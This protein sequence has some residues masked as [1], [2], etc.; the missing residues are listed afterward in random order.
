MAQRRSVPA[1]TS[2]GCKKAS[3]AIAPTD[4]LPL[5]EPTRNNWGM[6]D[7]DWGI[8]H[9]PN[10]GEGPIMV[11]TRSVPACTSLGCKKG[12]AAIAPTDT[13]PLPEPTRNNW[14]MMDSDWGINHAPNYGEGPIMAQRVSVP[15]CTSLGCK[16]ESMAYPPDTA[17][18]VPN[19]GKSNEHWQP[20][21]AP[22]VGEKNL[23]QIESIPSCTSFE[24]IS[25][26]AAQPFHMEKPDKHP[27][28][29]FVPNFGT[30]KEALSD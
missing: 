30:D 6:M 28:D 24:C 25:G 27:V 9:A 4:T 26:T 13:L 10:Y 23:I 14:G 11:Q 8:N 21:Y 16:K 20:D 5:P 1:C 17:T 29:Y 15:A 7:S 22:S 19:W 3:A 18:T 12:S 2:L